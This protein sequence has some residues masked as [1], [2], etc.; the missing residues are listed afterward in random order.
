MTILLDLLLGFAALS[1]AVYC[2]ILSR[3]LRALTRIDGALGGAVAVLSAQVDALTQALDTARDASDSLRSDLRG[4]TAEA[5]SA[6]RRLELLL[7]SLHDLPGPEG[8]GRPQHAAVPGAAAFAGA[9]AAMSGMGGTAGAHAQIQGAALSAG[10]MGADPDRHARRHGIGTGTRP[11]GAYPGT[12]HGHA[13]EG[14][15]PRQPGAFRHDTV[16]SAVAPRPS[17]TPA[18]WRDPDGTAPSGPPGGG[19]S[20]AHADAGGAM[21]TAPAA[22]SAPAT[23]SRILRRARHAGGSGA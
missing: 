4:Q 6:A 10:A 15:P 16:P 13:G 22:A 21:G 23:R 5:A 11:E 18:F 20:M 7:A 8:Q 2:L 12:R 14:P 3:R 19:T 17:V 1:A 9:A